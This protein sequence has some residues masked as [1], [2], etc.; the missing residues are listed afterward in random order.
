MLVT[1]A[2]ERDRLCKLNHNALKEIYGERLVLFE[3]SRNRL[4]GL[5]SVL[6]AFRGHFDGL[7]TAVIN[8][9]LQMI[10]TENVGKVFIDGSSL[11]GLVKIISKKFQQV[12]LFTFFHNVEARYFLG[13][14][15]HTK[16]LRALAVLMVN[17]L[18][19]R[20]AVHYSDRIIC[21]SERDSQMLKK[22]YGRSATDIAPM[23]LEDQLPAGFAKDL[24]PQTERFALFVGSSFYANRSGIAWF[25]N[26]VVPRIQIKICIVG[27][28]FEDLKDE[29]EREGKVEVVGAVDNLAQWYLNSHFVIAPIFDGSGM[30]TKVAE[31]LMFG[32][33]IIGTPEAFSGYEEIVGQAGCVCSTTDEFVA[34]IEREKDKV[35]KPFNPQLRGLYE[36]KY[37]YP[38]AKL[39]LAE[40]TGSVE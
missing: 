35:L 17:Y 22:V 12:Q 37:S 21:L 27:R 7:N 40:I 38:V 10:Q 33:K 19:E 29:L 25:I 16:T 39:R 3:L 13:W 23:A 34:A 2:G 1:I 11:G 26:N 24:S 31:A 15:R 6:N 5:R 14:L 4:K 36:E 8:R 20:K 18:S 28:G 30:K 32:K 9:A